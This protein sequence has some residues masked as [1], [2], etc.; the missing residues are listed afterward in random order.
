M[1][2]Q[3]F[4]DFNALFDTIHIG[5]FLKSINLVPANTSA[6]YNKVTNFRYNDIALS[7]T[8]M[9]SGNYI[10]TC[11]NNRYTFKNGKN[12]TL[13]HQALLDKEFSPISIETTKELAILIQSFAND[14]K[15]LKAKANA[16]S[17]L[18]VNNLGAKTSFL[19]NL[20]SGFLN[21]NETE[22]KLLKNLGIKELLKD[23]K[24]ELNHSLFVCR[25]FYK[26]LEEKNG[27]EFDFDIAISNHIVN[28]NFRFDARVKKPTEDKLR[29]QSYG[30]GVNNVGLY[31]N[32]GSKT[33]IIVEGQK[34]G[35][36]TYLS[37]KNIDVYAVPS[38]SSIPQ[39]L[40][41]ILERGEYAK[42]IIW[43]D[44]DKAGYM[45]IDKFLET[46]KK[47]KDVI[48]KLHY[49]SWDKI[50]EKH[51]AIKEIENAD[52][53]DVLKL[54]IEKNTLTATRKS[55]FKWLKNFAITS[56]NTEVLSKRLSQLTIEFL[57]ENTAQTPN[58][59]NLQRM[60]KEVDRLVRELKND[61]TLTN[62][63]E[64]L[65]A[66][67]N[68]ILDQNIVQANYTLE[69]EKGEY[70][71]H[72][73]KELQE[74]INKHSKILIYSAPGTGKSHWARSLNG[75]KLIVTPQKDLT[76]EF[77][78][79][80]TYLC[81]SEIDVNNAISDQKNMVMTTDFLVKYKD[82]IL[83]DKNR[84]DYIIF[85]EQHL[86]NQSNHFR[87]YVLEANK[88]IKEYIKDRKKVISEYETIIEL[89]KT[90][91]IYLSGTPINDDNYTTIL[92]KSNDKINLKFS[93]SD[94]QIDKIL[95]ETLT[96]NGNILNYQ[97][98]KLAVLEA[99]ELL[100][101]ELKDVIICAIT[102]KIKKILIDGEEKYIENLEEIYELANG[103]KIVFIATSKLTTGVNLKDLKHLII[104]G[105]TH[106][107][108]TFIQLLNRLRMDGEV[109]YQNK[110]THKR[111]E[112]IM[113]HML[114]LYTNFIEIAN[115]Y[116]SNSFKKLITFSNVRKLLESRID[117]LATAKIENGEYI[118]KEWDVEDFYK[119]FQTELTVMQSYGILQLHIERVNG[120]NTITDILINSFDKL[121]FL[122]KKKL[123][124]AVETKKETD[125]LIADTF[126]FNIKNFI[127]KFNTKINLIIEEEME[128]AVKFAKDEV[129]EVIKEAKEL[130]KEVKKAETLKILNEN[131]IDVEQE[132]FAL[133]AKKV[134]AINLL[135][136]KNFFENNGKFQHLVNA[137]LYNDESAI[138]SMIN[139]KNGLNDELLINELCKVTED[140]KVNF[141]ELG[142]SIVAS[143]RY[144]PVKKYDLQKEIKFL[145]NNLLKNS[146]REILKEEGFLIQ[147][148]A[149][150]FEL[151]KIKLVI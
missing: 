64:L 121:A 109:I 116:N 44:K 43:G 25:Y 146:T 40:S 3:N 37:I 90:K 39:E 149:I 65:V 15:N 55:F 110:R 133:V 114:G 98:T 33:L 6:T 141:E 87:W 122:E 38:S 77:V 97:P 23:Y 91:L 107:P 31:L 111:R 112:N 95:K 99:Y 9:E 5:E 70:L 68:K 96:K 27:Y 94:A 137:S 142:Q 139:F 2:S 30:S 53:T 32:R 50:V 140:R 67:S 11:W 76:Y 51:E 78:D 118:L 66:I 83:E 13:L 74:I 81:Q 45:L 14:P 16:N 54:E 41:E 19:R 80:N 128:V 92:V 84:F 60:L 58:L 130:K 138:K 93:F 69:L 46:F 61:K 82:I 126:K 22:A 75:L 17:N 7:V 123:I 115:S 120:I 57:K 34:D 24:K 105:T 148:D 147:K 150:Y 132:E 100:K 119:K 151:S 49:V 4:I 62:A 8:K 10:I 79:D 42:V 12:V 1:N 124:E 86:I 36:N 26:S 102:S 135:R 89:S 71:Q 18:E 88:L 103:R 72:K 145:A 48:K 134:K 59:E 47:S 73:S 143:G 104:S 108:Q 21:E 85:D 127:S 28:P 131:A 52:A 113:F 125:R 35:I 29:W 136:L 106:T 144:I 56:L 63:K 117:T 101:Q 129:A 20:D